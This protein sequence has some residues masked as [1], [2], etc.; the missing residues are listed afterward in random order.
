MVV[1]PL[2]SI[3]IH[4]DANQAY[5][6]YQAVQTYK[7]IHRETIFEKASHN[8]D[9]KGTENPYVSLTYVDLVLFLAEIQQQVL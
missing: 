4:G 7:L 8:F 2:K 1:W 5:T 9:L 3:S 6:C